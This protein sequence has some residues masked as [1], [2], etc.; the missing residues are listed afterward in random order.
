MLRI[1]SL[2]VLIFSLTACDAIG[3]FFAD[4]T[5]ND[6]ASQAQNSTSSEAPEINNPPPINN[7][8]IAGIEPSQPPALSLEG[9][10]VMD[11]GSYCW[12]GMCADMMTPIY[13]ESEANSLSDN[14]L[15]L[16]FAQTRPSSITAYVH[17]GLNLMTRI[18]DIPVDAVLDGDSV[19]ITLPE[20]LTGMYVLVVTAIWDGDAGGDAFYSLPISIGG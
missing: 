7:D 14:T 1:L 8:P 17:P 20:D 9:G 4:E 5:T 6:Q 2:I 19:T 18:A 13:E 12:S 16:T 3:D 10:I 15:T 11:L